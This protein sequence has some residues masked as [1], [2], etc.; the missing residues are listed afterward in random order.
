MERLGKQLEPT[1]SKLMKNTLI[2][3]SAMLVLMTSCENPNETTKQLHVYGNCMMCEDKIEGALKEVNGVVVGDWNRKTK[4][5]T[6]TFDSTK[7]SL[8]NLKKKIAEVG[9]DMDDVRAEDEVYQG[10]H[11]CCK[12]ERP[13]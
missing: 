6:L 2:I 8:L 1:S 13:E 7:T 9:Y 11:K 4:Q 5:M 12:Y 10:L 3:L